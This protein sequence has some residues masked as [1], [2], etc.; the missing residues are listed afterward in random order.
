M[1]THRL[2]AGHLEMENVLSHFSTARASGLK[3]K[4]N[5]PLGRPAK[6]LLKREKE[7]QHRAPSTGSDQGHEAENCALLMCYH[8]GLGEFGLGSPLTIKPKSPGL[9]AL[10]KNVDP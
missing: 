2:A 3:K 7:R 8:P 1:S 5:M 6:C 9:L 10:L 4:P